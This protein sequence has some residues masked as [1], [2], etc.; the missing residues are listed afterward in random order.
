[1]KTIKDFDCIK[2][3]NDIQAEIHAET[4]DMSFSEYK[5]YINS[6]LQKD[7]FWLSL[8][9]KHKNNNQSKVAEKQITW[10]AT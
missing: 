3:K 10:Q 2:M 4:K 1:M 9:D 8:Q 5:A 7:S 6:A